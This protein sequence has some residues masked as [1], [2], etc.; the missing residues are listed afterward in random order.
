MFRADANWGTDL[1]YDYSIYS[2][3]P[4]TINNIDYLGRGYNIFYGNP[5]STQGL[6]PGYTNYHILD[7]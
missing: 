2:H 7:L 6:D 1:S 4:K 3:L 5:H